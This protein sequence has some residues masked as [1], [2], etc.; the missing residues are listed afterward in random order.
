MLYCP[1]SATG[2]IS[3]I[4]LVKL[5]QRPTQVTHMSTGEISKG[6][7]GSIMAFWVLNFQQMMQQ[8]ATGSPR[9]IREKTGILPDVHRLLNRE[10]M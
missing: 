1:L 4:F 6:Q 5:L 2:L 10:L 3:I 9:Y 8:D 7:K